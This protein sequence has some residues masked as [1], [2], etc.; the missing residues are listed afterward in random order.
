MSK[1]PDLDMQDMRSWAIS[2]FPELASAKNSKLLER[3]VN[4]IYDYMFK[5]FLLRLDKYTILELLGDNSPNIIEFVYQTHPEEI[6]RAISP[7]FKGNPYAYL[8]C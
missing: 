6:E 1:L 2:V 5:N 8:K 4:E 3:V 7:S